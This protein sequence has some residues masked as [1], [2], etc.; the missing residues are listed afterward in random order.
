MCSWQSALVPPPPTHLQVPVRALPLHTCF[1]I[2]VSMSLSLSTAGPGC[3]YSHGWQKMSA[4][5]QTSNT[6]LYATRDSST[7]AP[8]SHA[9]IDCHKSVLHRYFTSTCANEFTQT[10]NPPLCQ[11]L[12]HLLSHHLRQRGCPRQ[13]ACGPDAAPQGR[14]VSPA[15]V[16]EV[17]G[18]DAGL[19]IGVGAG[20][21]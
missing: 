9:G 15:G 19:V 8:H 16:A 2:Y 1:L 14:Q 13:L 5:R 7:A 20:Q 6:A 4:V 18:G 17:S 3:T 12:P 21:A 10:C 11:P